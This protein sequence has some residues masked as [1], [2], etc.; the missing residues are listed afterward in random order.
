MDR[1]QSETYT[2]STATC[3]VWGE[4]RE[5]EHDSECQNCQKST[6]VLTW[7]EGWNYY[8][9][10][11]CVAEARMEAAKE[12]PAKKPVRMQGELFSEVA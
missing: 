12:A 10:D 11:D 4:V 9:C 8:G 7:V 5:T 6:P 1:F 3:R 2:A